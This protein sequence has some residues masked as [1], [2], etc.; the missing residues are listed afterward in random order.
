[1]S[2][3]IKNE[4]LFFSTGDIPV[5]YVEG[6][7]LPEAWEKSLIKLWQN[8]VAIKTQYDR[9]IDPPSRDA[10]MVMVIQKPFAEPRI[11]RALPTGLD[12]LEIYRQEVVLGIH[13]D[14]IGGHGWSYSYH[15]RLFN[16]KISGGNEKKHSK[17]LDQIEAVIK[18]LSDCFYTRRAQAITW[19][20]E[21]DA[22]HHEP[23]C[24]QRLWFRIIEDPKEGLILNMNSHWRS[25]DA[26]KAAF[27]N[28]FALTDLQQ[29]IAERISENIK[30]PVKAGRYA[31]ITDSYH[32]YGSYFEQFKGFLET[33]QTK[34]FEQRTYTTEF[35]QPF[36]EE[37][38]KKIS[39]QLK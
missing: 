15:D 4:N 19:D 31:D 11:H 9:K 38:A 22:G 33:L 2:S 34:T 24:L 20:P 39:G 18:N 12:E 13:D 7:S 35:C 28:I 25:R 6:Q 5:L 36:F 29:K 3:K 14:W 17:H 21:I 10:T 1:M 16:Y 8:G 23:P 26:F 37:A 27:M 32:I 30:Q